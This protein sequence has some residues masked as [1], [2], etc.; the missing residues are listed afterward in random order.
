MLYL[1]KTQYKNCYN[2]CM[3]TVRMNEKETPPVA[4]HP[5]LYPSPVSLAH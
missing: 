4:Y 1:E 2:E 3:G 5:L